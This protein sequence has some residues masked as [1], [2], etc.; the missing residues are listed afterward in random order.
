MHQLAQLLV[1]QLKN[2]GKREAAAAADMAK[3]SS[4]P[5]IDMQD[6][7]GLAEKIVKA[8]EEWGCFRLVN[9][10]VPMELM[11]EMKGVTR[12][13][14]DLP[15][16]IK[17]KNSHPEP[18]KGYT[19]PNMAS[20][21]F[22][23]LSLYDMTSPGAFDHF[24]SQ[25]DASPHQMEVLEKYAFALYDLAQ[26]LGSKLM[27]GLGLSGELFKGWPCQLKMNKYNYSPETVGLTG[28]VMH[29]DPG[30]LTI[31]QD[32]EV[33]N[34]LE[35]VDEIT[36]ELVSVDPIPGTL[37]VNVGDVA[38]VWSNGRFHNVKHRVQCYESTDR[39]SIS[40]F[41][42]AP[43][44]EKVEAAAEL[45]DSDHPRRYLPFHFEEYRKLRVSK[46]SGNGEALELFS[47]KN[48]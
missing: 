41:A 1:S 45:V 40:F 42:L 28:A 46:R 7:S 24:C 22:E 25:I 35:A 44:D 39:I 48:F 14:M 30:F 43:K 19:P 23:G 32:D 12:S 17:Q 18:G 16:E 10:G 29:T 5:V 27:E 21:Y 38:T 37:V 15:M 33:V 6:L 8:C 4:V 13:L 9:H 36:G 34:G 47:T 20:P 11:A 26:L 2:S 3:R 31:L